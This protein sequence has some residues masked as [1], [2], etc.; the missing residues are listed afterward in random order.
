MLV[1]SKTGKYE[2][3][4]FRETA[5]AAAFQHMYN[6][7][8]NLSII[9]GLASGIP[10]ELRGL[11]YL[12]KNYGKLSW[13]SVVQP[14]VHV[15]RY[16]FPV[17]KD[18]VRYIGL[19]IGTGSNFLKDNPSWALDFAPNGTLVGLGDTLTRKRYA[20][21]LETISIHGAEAFYTGAIAN[22]TITALQASNGTMTL[23]DLKH[24]KVKIRDPVSIKYK[25]Y[26]LHACSAP[27]GGVVALAALNIFNGYETSN[28]ST[29]NLTTHHL[30]E[31]MKWAYGQ[32]TQLGDPSFAPNLTTFQANMLSQK[33]AREIRAQISDATTFTTSHYD[34]LGIQSLNDSGTSHVVT[35]DKDGLA[36][37]LT[38]TINLL[39]GSRLIIPET[40]IIM[41]NEMN[42]F[43]IPGY[44]RPH[45][46]P[47][48][49]YI[50]HVLTVPTLQR[51]KRIRLHPQYSKL[52]PPRQAPPVI[53]LPHHRRDPRWQT[54]PSRRFRRRLPNNNRYHPKHPPHARRRPQS[55]ASTRE[56][57]LTR[58][59]N[60]CDYIF[61]EVRIE[62]RGV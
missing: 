17:G 61:R 45:C 21:T 48:T 12:H 57:P 43:S 54:L 16:G 39:F 47:Q 22:T 29:I 51:N 9:G 50:S 6:K 42:D 8:V 31:S 3:I 52:H 35:A 38:T 13:K 33:T 1:R 23:E 18:L 46:T 19:G 11:E 28:P 34:P 25:D 10:G 24:Y 44:V 37:T 62:C 26:T 36:I 32:R 2:F 7:N 15:A 27:S 4:D 60:A 20:D 56:T 40:G 53:H 41:N 55:R 14:A 30:V 49:P 59:I 5:P 58:P